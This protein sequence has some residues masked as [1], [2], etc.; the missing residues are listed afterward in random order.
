MNRRFLLPAIMAVLAFTGVANAQTPRLPFRSVGSF[1][2]DA[3]NRGPSWDESSSNP[4]FRRSPVF[5]CFWGFGQISSGAA[6]GVL[7]TQGSVVQTGLGS[8]TGMGSTAYFRG[9]FTLSS[10]TDEPVAVSLNLV[11][12]TI[13]ATDGGNF[14]SD[15]R[16]RIDQVDFHYGRVD[17]GGGNGVPDNGVRGLFTTSTVMVT[18]N[19]PHELELELASN[20]SAFLYVDATTSLQSELTLASTGPVFNLP[21]GVTVSDIPELG[22]AGNRWVGPPFVVDADTTQP[23]LDDLIDLQGSFLMNDVVGRTTLELP[24]LANVGCNFTVTNNPDLTSLSMPGLQGV[25]CDVD[26]SHN[27][28]LED[29]DLSTGVIGGAVTITDNSN[30]SNVELTTTG[31]IGGTVTITD[32]SNASNIKVEGQGVLGGSVVIEDN[33]SAAVDMTVRGGVGGSVIIGGNGGDVDMSV[34]GGVGGSVVLDGNSNTYMAGEVTGDVS[35]DVSVRNNATEETIELEVGGGIGGDLTVTDNNEADAIGLEVGG[36]IGGDLTVVDNGDAS[37]DV[38]T[39][40]VRGDEVI[41]VGGEEVSSVTADGT[42]TVTLVNGPATMT[43]ELETGTFARGV[44]FSIDSLGDQPA[45]AGTDAAQRPA[46]IEAI[47]AYQFTFEIPTLNRDATL[48]FEVDVAA[49]G[50]QGAAFLAALDAGRATLATRGDAQG[51]AFQSFNVCGG[52]AAPTAAGCVR[53]E[54]LD[55]NGAPIAAGTPARVR[56]TG[57]TGHFSSFAVVMV[58]LIDVTAPVISNVPANMVATAGG[59]G[60]ALV[61]YA[62]PSALDDRDGNV[63]V[64]CLPGSGTAFAMGATTVRCV[65]QDAAGNRSE[66]S[67][68]VT[69]SAAPAP[70]PAP[71][72]KGGGGAIDPATLLLG[73]LALAATLMRGRSGTV[74]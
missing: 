68:T 3:C 28:A 59:S 71:P 35:G 61:T 15:V 45:S 47:A 65:A 73:L 2:T 19:V 70:A 49:L 63:P 69:V 22:V 10:P 9:I 53:V 40:Y 43:V 56:F 58:T 30:A 66:A 12:L 62:N 38:D 42:T 32:N 26:I 8:G 27:P 4:I 29:V 5:D 50:N 33:D 31:V 67:F 55:A 1:G 36:G 60:T 34:T 41:S 14:N 44:I 52:G 74:S 39:E 20:V 54:R 37:V 13:A 16:A 64:S 7:T 46:M 48:T 51:S 57:V 18:P 23:M 11:M 6:P 25:G 21:T 24:N 17:Q 72:K